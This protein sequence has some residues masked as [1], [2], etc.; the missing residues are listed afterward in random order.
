[1]GALRAVGR[2]SVRAAARGGVLPFDAVTR[3]G[4][5]GASPYQ[6]PSA[7]EHVHVVETCDAGRAGARPYLHH[8]I[9]SQMTRKTIGIS[10]GA[11]TPRN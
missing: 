11:L 10:T 7:W 6:P 3:L 4:S 9:A 8:K 2:G 1:M 5:G